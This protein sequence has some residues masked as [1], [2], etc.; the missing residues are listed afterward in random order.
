MAAYLKL[1]HIDKS[2]ARGGA[3]QR[4]ADATSR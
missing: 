3:G 2:F 4:S 1:D